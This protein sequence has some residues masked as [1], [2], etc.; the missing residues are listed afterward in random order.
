MGKVS[1]PD[2]PVGFSRTSLFYLDIS[3]GLNF[4]IALGKNSGVSFGVGAYHLNQPN[5]SFLGDDGEKLYSRWVVQGSGEIGFGEDLPLSI[6]PS[7]VFMYQGP[8]NEITGSIMAKWKANEDFAISGGI[9][10]RT[11]DAFIPM[12]RIDYKI[13]SLAFSYDMN[14]ST[15]N[16]A[17]NSNG[18]MEL[19][20]IFRP[21]IFNEKQACQTIFCPY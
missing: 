10:Y 1:I 5:V 16:T 15:L 12:I 9:G 18:G 11:S 4:S 7:V 8:H 20:L 3:A 19:S 14:N 6:I 2:F 17:S 13:A 21:S